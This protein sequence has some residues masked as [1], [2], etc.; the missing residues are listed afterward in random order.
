M[1]DDFKIKAMTGFCV[2]F[3]VI[4]VIAACVM[5]AVFV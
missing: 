1:D 3:G 4:C 5:Y 2:A